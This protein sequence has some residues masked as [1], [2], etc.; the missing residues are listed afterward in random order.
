M[1]GICDG[2]VVIVTG[3]GRG[4]GRCH[5]LAYAAEGAR[6]VVN[7][8]GGEVDGSGNSS[9]PAG[10]VVEEIRSLGGQAVVDASDV[11]TWQGAE[12]LVGT[13]INA[14]GRLDVLVN[15]AG[16]L[17]DRMLVNMTEQEWDS[18]MAVHL[19]GT[20]GPSHFAALHWRDRSKAGETV[21]GRLI[22]TSS[23]SGLYGNPGQTNYGAAK[24]G[25]AA[26][27]IIAAKELQR[28]GVTVN[29]VAPGA[30]TRMTEPLG[31]GTSKPG[32][33]Q[34]DAFAP[35]NISP[36]VVWLGSERSQRVTGRVFNVA[37][38]KISVAEGW[39]HGPSVDKASRWAPEE[40]DE[41]V[42]ELLG[43]AAP[44]ADMFA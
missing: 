1:A 21:S 13:A 6:I 8:L 41:V 27:T 11:S 30:R 3:A 9:G 29:A 16:I 39:R 35:E 5:A 44:P 14:F 36:L 18:V 24:A 17:R 40:F 23:A 34:F 26:F 12:K 2:R 4:I 43:K 42:V 33:D 10:S 22:N 31:Y 28:Y 15:N 20:F 7:D 25:I 32:V 19:K 37:G 38:G